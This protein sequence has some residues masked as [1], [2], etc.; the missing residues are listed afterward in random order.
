MEKVPLSRSA[1]YIIFLSLS[2]GHY[3]LC[4]DGIYIYLEAPIISGD[5]IG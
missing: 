4:H 5:E 1:T 2:V 3:E